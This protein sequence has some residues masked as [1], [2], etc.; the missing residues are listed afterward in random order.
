MTKY[1]LI[2]IPVHLVIRIFLGSSHGCQSLQWVQLICLLCLCL[3]IPLSFHMHILSL[4]LGVL[5]GLVTPACSYI[6][7]ESILCHSTVV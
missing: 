5:G 3:S 2:C 1:P 7:S 6:L 4:E